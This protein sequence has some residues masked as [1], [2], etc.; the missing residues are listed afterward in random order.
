M[1]NTWLMRAG[2]MVAVLAWTSARA[3]PKQAAGSSG[4]PRPVVDAI[5]STFAGSTIGACKAEHGHGHDQLEVKVVKGDGTKVE[6]DV[7]PDGKILQIEETIALD[8][9][10]AAVSKAFAARYPQAKVSTAEKQTPTGGSP[11]YELGF[12]TAHGRKEATF[13]KDGTFVEEE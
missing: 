12:A 5:A 11:S 9:I 1:A 4:C 3:E 7:T 2:M 8:Q 10:P 6:V 13:R